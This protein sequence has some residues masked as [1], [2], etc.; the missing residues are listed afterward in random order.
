MHTLL[1]SVRNPFSDGG[2]HCR[3]CPVVRDIE[4]YW[5][6][7]SGPGRSSN[8][9]IRRRAGSGRQRQQG[10]DRAHKL[11]DSMALPAVPLA[12]FAMAHTWLIPTV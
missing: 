11:A 1:A 5:A 8:A 6:E 2:G 7:Q 9:Y 12:A 10:G 3:K 4:R